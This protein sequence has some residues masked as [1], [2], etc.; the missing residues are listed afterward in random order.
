M[1]QLKQT[2][3]FLIAGSQLLHLYVLIPHV[4]TVLNYWNDVRSVTWSNNI[5]ETSCIGSC[6]CVF[7]S[8]PSVH[9]WQLSWRFDQVDCYLV[10]YSPFPP[11]SQGQTFASQDHM[12]KERIGFK[13]LLVMLKNLCPHLYA[14]TL[15][16]SL[17]LIVEIVP[18]SD[19]C[20]K[21][22]CLLL[23]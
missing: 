15:V 5:Q 19:I 13:S 14:L 23:M 2:E 20:H 1:V 18:Y 17:N 6:G 22:L 21:C 4:L 7:L 8:A 9:I 16:C 11:A 12:L 3:V 10:Q